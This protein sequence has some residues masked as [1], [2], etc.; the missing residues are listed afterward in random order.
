MKR[1]IYRLSSMG[2]VILSQSA[3]EVPYSGTTDWV[4]LSEFKALLENHPRLSRVWTFDRKKEGLREW[5]RLNSRLTELGYDEVLD[6]HSSYRTRVAYWVFRAHAWFA[7]KRMP[8]WKRLRK[9]RWRRWGYLIFKRAWPADWRPRA[10]RR[11]C[12]RLAGGTGVERPNLRHLIGEPPETLRAD[13][14]PEPYY[15]VMPASAWPGKQW[16]VAYYS[17][18]VRKFGDGLAV[19]AG[20]AKD[21]A[22]NELVRRLRKENAVH[23]DAVGKFDLKQTAWL[24]AR[25]RFLIANDTGLSHLAEAVGTPVIAFYGPTRWD[26]GFGISDPKSK[27]LESDVWCSPCSKDG[28]LCYRLTNRFACL[29]S[30]T[31]SRAIE[32]ARAVEAE[33]GR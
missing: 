3:L 14:L 32:V 10:L 19:I 5:I 31:P 17:E 21:E 20:T 1:L 23:R 15:V 7:G 30:M 8:T 2:D 28:T 33:T 6:L 13:P 4:T 24:L 12:A 9:A 22:S 26:F 18:F 25:A 29:K 16:P 11:S 27:A